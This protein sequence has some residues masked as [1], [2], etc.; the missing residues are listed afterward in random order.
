M[1]AIAPLPRKLNRSAP[2]LL[3]AALLA[4]MGCGGSGPT[5]APVKGKVLLDGQPLTTG[6]VST[7]PAA[8]RGANGIIHSDGTFTLSS[9]REPGALVGTHQVAIVAFEGGASSSPEGPQGKLLTPQRY[10]TAATSG[11]SL[12]VTNGENTPTL[13]LTS[14]K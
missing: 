8:G 1:P 5:L 9:G 3:L 13:E 6:T 2:G 10:A 12:E 11:L 4:A 14:A 7:Q